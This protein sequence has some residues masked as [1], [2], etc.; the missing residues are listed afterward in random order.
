MCRTAEGPVCG[1]DRLLDGFA[2]S[3][4]LGRM[5]NE[6]KRTGKPERPKGAQ[7]GARLRA[8]A[9]RLSGMARNAARRRGRA[10]IYGV[11]G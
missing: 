8:R 7:I 10:L 5:P 2:G 3:D 4:H 1:R 11:A 6:Q 9:N